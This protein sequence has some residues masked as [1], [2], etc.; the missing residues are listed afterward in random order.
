[1]VRTCI[2]PLFRA[3]CVRLSR[4]GFTV[5]SMALPDLSVEGGEAARPKYERLKAHL[6]TEMREGPVSYTHLTLP[7]TERE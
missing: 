3:G 5:M 1:M 7:T 2:G 4:S 6:L